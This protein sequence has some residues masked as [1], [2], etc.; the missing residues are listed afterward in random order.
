MAKF[1]VKNVKS[2]IDW[3]NFVLKQNPQS[4]LHSWNWGQVNELLGY[5]P[6]RIGFYQKEVLKGVSLMILQ[7]AKRGPHFL[8]PGGPLIDWKNKDLVE[9]F[10]KAT[11]DI[12]IR[13]KVWFVRVRPEILDTYE[14]RQSFKSLGFISAPMH[15]HAEQTW[16]LNI[17]K[18]KEDLLKGMRKSTRYLVRKSLNS[19][20][21]FHE[22]QDPKDISFLKD[23]QEETVER[24]KFVGFSE[25]IFSSQLA[26]F[27]KNNEARLFL[28]KKQKKVLV[29]AIIIF[30]GGAAYYHHSASSFESRRTPASYFLQWKVI[31]KAQIRGCKYYNFWGIAPNDDP[32]HRFAGVTLFKKG[33]GGERIDW[34]HAQDLPVSNLYWLTFIFETGRR[35][36]RRL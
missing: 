6:I 7:K 4:F 30:Y 13:E 8:I 12:A 23:L 28:V 26:T 10:L 33:F 2:K 31:E 34:L 5:K 1:E 16:V 32:K 21:T 36:I 14:A 25:K 20:L 24:H 17:D 9:V 18:D 22:S 35:I 27:G 15:L 29:A 11:R 19:G 3:E